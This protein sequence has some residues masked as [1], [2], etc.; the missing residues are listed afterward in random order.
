MTITVGLAGAGRR[1]ARVHA[2]ALATAPDIEFAGIWALGPGRVRAL[3]DRHGVQAFWEFGDLLENCDAVA[4]AVP[5]AAQPDLAATAV[6]RGRSVL[7][8]RPIAGD[9]AG[10]EELAKTVREKNVVSQIG[11]AWRYAAQVRDFLRTDVERVRPVSGRGRVLSDDHLD[12]DLAATW[13]IERGV[14]H[15]HGVDLLDLL[16]ATLGPITGVRAHGDP[17]GWIGLLLDHLGGHHSEA[18]MSATVPRGVSRAE[19]EICGPGGAATLD[20]V[21][22]VG[23]PAYRTMYAEFADAVERQVTPALDVEHG[24]HLQRVIEAADTDIVVGS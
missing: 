16:G 13:R 17:H 8:E 6:E 14:L 9:L 22:V 5:P 15:D 23:P 24:L 1:A 10:A 2:P 3:A 21:G 20:C 7:L 18:S 12:D 4:F 19:V 11:L